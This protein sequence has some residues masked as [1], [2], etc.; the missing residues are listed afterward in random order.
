MNEKA[1]IVGLKNTHFMNPQGFDD[2][3]HY[4]TVE[5]LALLTHYA[6][7]NYPLIA[8]IVKKDYVHLEA[9]NTHRQFDLYNWNGLLDV[10]PNVM[11][12]KIG[13][14]DMAGTT[15]IVLSEREG[16]RML[17]ILL[18]APNV[19][20]RDIWTAGLLDMG[21]E[22]TKGLQPIEVS[23]SDLA[24]KYATWKTWN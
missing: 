19:L 23:E 17:A 15:T 8:E 20:K 5:D 6:L 2:S 18:G 14:T 1:A 9:N 3:Q 11:G 7:T 10:Y 12:V 4:S 21:F 16:K 22:K 24:A 13:N